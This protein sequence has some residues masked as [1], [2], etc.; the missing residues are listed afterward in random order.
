[1]YK[2]DLE[3]LRDRVARDEI[4]TH[5]AWTIVKSAKRSWNSKEWK[6]KA[7]EVKDTECRKCGSKENLLIQHLWHPEVPT[8]YQIMVKYFNRP[9]CI[10]VGTSKYRYWSQKFLKNKELVYKIQLLLFIDESIKYTSLE[11]GVETLCRRCAYIDDKLM[12][13]I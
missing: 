3:K 5:D 2:S 10:K 4:S 12:C 7:K 13:A 8:V 11:H 6:K 9:T 1:M